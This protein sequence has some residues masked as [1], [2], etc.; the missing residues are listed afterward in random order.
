MTCNLEIPD[1]FKTYLTTAVLL[2]VSFPTALELIFYD[3]IAYKLKQVE[4]KIS[5]EGINCLE[6]QLRTYSQ[7]ILQFTELIQSLNA[8]EMPKEKEEPRIKKWTMKFNVQDIENHEGFLREVEQKNVEFIE[9]IKQLLLEDGIKANNF[10][11]PLFNNQFA[12]F[13]LGLK[14][15]YD[16]T[17]PDKHYDE[18][19]N[20]ILMSF[21]K[22]NYEIFV[23]N[24]V[25]TLNRLS[26]KYLENE[27]SEANANSIADITKSA[28]KNHK[29][30][31][32]TIFELFCN[33][34]KQILASCSDKRGFFLILN[35]VNNFI[36]K[37][38]KSL[39]DE[40]YKEISGTHYMKTYDKKYYE[41]EKCS[42]AFKSMKYPFLYIPDIDPSSNIDKSK[43]YSVQ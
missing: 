42:Y 32:L 28:F 2:S 25:K 19:V 38:T 33:I 5:V 15:A 12:Y 16:M 30:E 18:E 20:N 11:V 24:I 8:E 4:T 31:S 26:K 40:F 3:Y 7:V 43:V 14:R 1:M 13:H 6:Y 27:Q 21:M 34:I 9:T 41:C 22:S 17:L 37:I 23:E 36:E 39:K 10:Q 29:L 35:L